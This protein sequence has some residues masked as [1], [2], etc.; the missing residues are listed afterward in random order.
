MVVNNNGLV[1][2]A[3]CTC[4]PVWVVEVICSS[5]G[6]V[7]LSQGEVVTCRYMEVNNNG[8]VEVVSCTCKLVREVEVICSSKELVK[9]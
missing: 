9:A 7:L 1:E 2:V 6:L 4:K 3:S 5:K 8:L